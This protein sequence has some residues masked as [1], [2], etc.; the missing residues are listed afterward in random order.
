MKIL[1]KNL[2]KLNNVSIRLVKEAPV[3]SKEPISS[4]LSA[5]KLVKELISELDREVICIINLKTSNVPINFTIASVG[6]LDAS[7]ANPR[8]MLKTTILSNAA[9]IILVHNHPSGSLIPSKED[10][11]ITDRINKLT[12]ML[13]VGLLDH[14]I[15]SPESNEYFSF[16]E[17]GIMTFPDEKYEN[18]YQKLELACENNDFYQ[19][20]RKG[21]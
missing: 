8:E 12:N 6:Q 10:T 13:G 18:D 17:K 7:L 21:R 16:K 11:V 9:K 14:V 3:I 19:A 4:P 2:F 5:L 15:I 1:A 20:K